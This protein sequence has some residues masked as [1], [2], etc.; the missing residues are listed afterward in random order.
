MSIHKY[1]VHGRHAVEVPQKRCKACGKEFP[2]SQEYFKP[3][4]KS[5]G[6][7]R[8][9]TNNGFAPLCRLCELTEAAVKQPATSVTP[10]V[11]TLH[12]SAQRKP[13]ADIGAAPVL[14]KWLLSTP[15]KQG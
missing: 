6:R 1:E 5:S 10:E 11:L 7:N 4:F 9:E 2:R 12:K 15:P 3:R 14:T 8:A 13:K